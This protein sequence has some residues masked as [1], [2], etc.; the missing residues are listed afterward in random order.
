MVDFLSQEP[1]DSK[2]DDTKEL[3][4][5]QLKLM[6]DSSQNVQ[7]FDNLKQMIIAQIY[8]EQSKKPAFCSQNHRNRAHPHG[9]TDISLQR[10]RSGVLLMLT[11]CPI[12]S[13]TGSRVDPPLLS[14]SHTLSQEH[15]GLN[16]PDVQSVWRICLFSISIS[17]WCIAMSTFKQ[18]RT[19]CS[20]RYNMKNK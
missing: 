18:I 13:T 6:S 17:A 8:K 2:S 16:L 10:G 7:W 9:S 5:Y 1:E 19:H 3:Q 14:L 20:N 12:Y 4:Y 11:R 15:H